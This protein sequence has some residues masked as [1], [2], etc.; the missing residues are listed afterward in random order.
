MFTRL[1]IE[2]EG[3]SGSSS[4]GYFCSLVEG[5]VT[6]PTPSCFTQIAAIDSVHSTHTQVFIKQTLVMAYVRY[7]RTDVSKHC[8]Y[9]DTFIM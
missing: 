9:P 1:L 4:V 7:N 3:G 5:K 2:M 6:S 8:R